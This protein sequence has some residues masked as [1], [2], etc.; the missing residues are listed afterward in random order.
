MS[1]ETSDPGPAGPLRARLAS[2]DVLA[3][4]LFL[5]LGLAGLWLNEYRV[6]QAARMGPGYMPMLVFGGLTAMGG[7]VAAVGLVRP[8]PP[9]ERVAIVALIWILAALAVFAL[10]IERLGLMVATVLLV[11][12]A[13]LAG[14]VGKPLRV[15][16][17]AVGLAV[18]SLA[19]FVWGLGVTIRV[20][21]WTF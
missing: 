11:A 10:T 9:V 2:R 19:V 13:S 12:V 4:V 17:L 6:G 7:F 16:A 18:F 15:L 20:W 21:P 3:G 1:A 14:H 5:A 8:G